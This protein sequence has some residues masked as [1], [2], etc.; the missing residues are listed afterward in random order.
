VGNPKNVEIFKKLGINTAISAAFTIA[1]MLEQA[2]ALEDIVRSMQIEEKIV[3]TEIGVEPDFEVAG[4]LIMDIKFPEDVIVSC[5][6]RG[7]DMIVPRG[8]TR[9]EKGDKLMFISAPESQKKIINMFTR[10]A[11]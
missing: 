8:S 9:I 11:K 4:K 2:T 6:L 5:I 3:L 7:E 1:Q 10:E